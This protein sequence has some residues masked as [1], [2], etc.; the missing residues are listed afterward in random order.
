MQL[1]MFTPIHITEI[2]H[3]VAKVKKTSEQV[4][5]GLFARY[6]A[7]QKEFNELRGHLESQEREI[8]RLKQAIYAKEDHELILVAM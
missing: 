2:Q 6:T 5:K 8:Y 3:E 1:D 7:L 4:R